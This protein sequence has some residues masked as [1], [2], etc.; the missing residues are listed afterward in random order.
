MQPTNKPG[1]LRFS[2]GLRIGL[3][4]LA[5]FLFL[6]TVAQTAEAAPMT[7]AIHTTDVTCTGVDLN[8]YTSKL[9]VYLE[10]GPARVGAAG[11]PQGE[12]YVKITAPNGDLLGTSLGTTDETPIVVN[13]SGEFASCYQLWAILEKASDG[14]TGYDD[15]TNNGGEYKV[16]VCQTSSFNN[17]TCKTDNFKVTREEPGTPPSDACA[18]FE[19]RIV[20]V[21]DEEL[22]RD[23]GLASLTS[24]VVGASIPVGSYNLTLQSSDN[25][26]AHNPPQV[27]Q[28]NERWFARFNLA[29]GGPVDSAA[30]ADLPLDQDVLN[31]SLGEVTF[32]AAVTSVQ[33]IHVGPLLAGAPDSVRAECVALDPAS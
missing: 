27:S 7:G 4:A 6:L 13:A 16:W 12:Y 11:L 30:I 19:G 26:S 28:T 17:S 31:Q 32:A 8:H 29:E 24:D 9:D 22:R 14:T 33:A 10:G 3:A 25:H 2:G 1:F 20:I 21:F 18:A 5:A 15:T 23:Q